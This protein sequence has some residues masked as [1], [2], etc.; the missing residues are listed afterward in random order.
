MHAS[1]MDRKVICDK[2]RKR[3]KEFKR[4]PNQLSQRQNSQTLR[5]EANEGITYELS[6]GLN[7]DISNNRTVPQIVFDVPT[8]LSQTELRRY[9][10][11]LPPYTASPK[12]I[13]LPYDSTQ[14]YQFIIFDRNHM[15]R[16][17]S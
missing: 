1:A 4:R 3:T 15:Y 11:I 16:K 5:R 9:E 14:K 10:E 12:V 13:N 17:A 7:L 2:Q 8:E 6:V